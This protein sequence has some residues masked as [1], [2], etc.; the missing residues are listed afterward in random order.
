M[1][2]TKNNTY[3]QWKSEFRKLDKEI[4]YFLKDFVQQ[5]S[6][7]CVVDECKHFK[8][9]RKSLFGT[10]ID[11]LYNMKLKIGLSAISEVVNQN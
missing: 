10:R 2:D 3:H 8:Q 1:D 9:N 7:K 6:C 5:K 4:D 11:A